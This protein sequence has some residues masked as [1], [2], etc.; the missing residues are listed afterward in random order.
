MNV[1]KEPNYC[2]VADV[3]KNIGPVT[4]GAGNVYESL[5]VNNQQSVV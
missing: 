5:K 2:E 4:G 3:P 1:D